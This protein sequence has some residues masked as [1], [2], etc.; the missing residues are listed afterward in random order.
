M[1]AVGVAQVMVVDASR[2]AA[3]MLARGDSPDQAEAVAV[4]IAP[5]GA[6][7]AV[8]HE[9]DWVRVVTTAEVRAPASVL[10]RFAAVTV[11]SEAV[12]VVEPE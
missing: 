9:G 4:R 5:G 10:G 8:Q 6:D 11:R 1:L 3:R 2:E 12:A 7:V